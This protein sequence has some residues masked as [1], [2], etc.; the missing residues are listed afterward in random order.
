MIFFLPV[1]SSIA[2]FLSYRFQPFEEIILSSISQLVVVNKGNDNVAHK[3]VNLKILLFIYITYYS[4]KPS[5]MT[6]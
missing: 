6:E 4:V 5:L 2:L 1:V 3:I